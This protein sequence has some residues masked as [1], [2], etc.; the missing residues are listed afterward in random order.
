[1]QKLAL[2]ALVATTLAGS[3]TGTAVAG[4]EAPGPTGF[5]CGYSSLTNPNAE[6]HTQTAVVDGGAV[7]VVDEANN[8]QSG[9]LTCTIQVGANSTHAGAD[10]P[11]GKVSSSGTGV[12]VIPPTVVSYT[13]TPEQAVYV[14]TQFTYTGGGTVYYDADGDD[15][16]T[17]AGHWS[18]DADSACGP[19][20]VSPAPGEPGPVEDLVLLIDAI[21]CPV[22][23]ELLP[24]DG[25]VAGIW[26][27]PPYGS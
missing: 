27:C 10:A 11:G 2:A 13:A 9:T 7:V 18:A 17:D 24:P 8:P 20:N 19:F 5:V 25:D 26:E 12:V 14:C 16:S 23:K 1:M 22:L 3:F 21:A 6:A 15:G 4:P